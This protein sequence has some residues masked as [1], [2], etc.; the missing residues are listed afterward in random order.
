[1]TALEVV[2]SM[3]NLEKFWLVFRTALIYISILLVVVIV[4]LALIK[5]W[6]M[7]EK[8]R[9]NEE[10][11]LREIR[12]SRQCLAKLRLEMEELEIRKEQMRKEGWL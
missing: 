7:K 8:K 5:L 10:K 4:A 12:R 9:R 3:S 11:R 2:N 1:M 6:V